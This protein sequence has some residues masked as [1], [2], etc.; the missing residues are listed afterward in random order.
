V[1]GSYTIGSF[2]GFICRKVLQVSFPGEAKV[3]VQRMRNGENSCAVNG[4]DFVVTREEQQSDRRTVKLSLSY[5][6]FCLKFNDW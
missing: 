5:A 2:V 4:E 3:G 1:W 6:S